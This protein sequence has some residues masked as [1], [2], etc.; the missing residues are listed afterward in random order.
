MRTGLGL[1]VAGVEGMTEK[2]TFA[3]VALRVPRGII[4]LLSALSFHGLTTQLPSEIWVA[5]GP[6]ARRPNGGGASIHP[7]HFSGEALT[8]GVE[9]HEIEKVAVRIYSAGKTVADCFKHRNKIGMD[10]AREALRDCWAKRKATLDELWRYA[11]ICRVAKVM[12]PYMES[13]T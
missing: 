10:V 12:Q 3:E 4:C 13:L 8:A 6:K 2:H 5:I 1:Y 9:V 11:K 7:I